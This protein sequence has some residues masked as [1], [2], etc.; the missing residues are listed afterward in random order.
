LAGE[1]VRNR[2]WKR[3]WQASTSEAGA[4]IG[5][6]KLVRRNRSGEAVLAG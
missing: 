5:V 2:G 4:A 3:F 6:G 1:Y